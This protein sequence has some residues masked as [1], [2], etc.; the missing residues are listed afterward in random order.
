[1]GT[2]VQMHERVGAT[3]VCVCVSV[4]MCVSITLEAGEGENRQALA[5]PQR[6]LPF[7]KKR[8]DVVSFSEGFCISK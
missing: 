6:Y 5:R 3:C 8:E 2:S 1:M 4:R 7:S